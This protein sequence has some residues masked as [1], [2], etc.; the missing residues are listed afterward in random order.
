MT[1]DGVFAA[2]TLAAQCDGPGALPCPEAM[3]M[4]YGQEACFC[5]DPQAYLARCE[6]DWEQDRYYPAA[7]Y[8]AL[9]CTH[10]KLPLP[11]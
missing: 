4:W 7:G 9:F 3:I 1:A 5:V 2:L 6:R 10:N 8:A 11:D